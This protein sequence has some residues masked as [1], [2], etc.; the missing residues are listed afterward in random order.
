MDH[1]LGTKKM[2]LEEQRE[3]TAY[4]KYALKGLFYLSA[5]SPTVASSDLSGKLR[6]LQNAFKATPV[7]GEPF[8]VLI[9]WP[10]CAGLILA[11]TLVK[12]L[13]LSSN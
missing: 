6:D 4:E 3:M 10:Q 5:D 12:P 1:K 13:L 7:T 9:R 8:P 11:A 2:V